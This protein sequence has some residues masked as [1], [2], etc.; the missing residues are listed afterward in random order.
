MTSQLGTEEADAPS[1]HERSGAEETAPPAVEPSGLAWLLPTATILVSLILGLVLWQCTEPSAE[2]AA[3]T[4]EGGLIAYRVAGCA[5]CHGQTGLGGTGPALGGHSANQVARQVRAP[6]GAMP[7]FTPSQVTDNNLAAIVLFVGGL[8]PVDHSVRWGTADGAGLDPR[9]VLAARHW[10]ALTAIRNGDIAET[11][12][13]IEH[14]N[15]FIGG[16]HLEAMRKISDLLDQGE[17]A[18]A[19]LRLANMSAGVVPEAAVL[20]SLTL[21]LAASE[22]EG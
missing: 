19:E 17:I 21:A 3:P 9:D 20:D 2:T 22:S 16:E 15:E 13:Q 1:T 14:M 12:N 10:L 11:A 4:A 6:F 18:G 5:A 8:E 7:M